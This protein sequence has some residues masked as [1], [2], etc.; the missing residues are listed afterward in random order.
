MGFMAHL[1]RFIFAAHRSPSCIKLREALAP[2]TH[3]PPPAASL[4]PSP[5]Q[6]RRLPPTCAPPS[7]WRGRPPT[8][9]VCPP[10][11]RHDGGPL[12]Q[13]YIRRAW[14]R[15]PPSGFP[16]AHGFGAPFRRAARVG[17]GLG[18]QR[19]SGAAVV[20]REWRGPISGT[21][22]VVDIERAHG[23]LFFCFSV[24]TVATVHVICVATVFCF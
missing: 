6:P 14:R 7:L 23:A 20:G 3:S 18:G 8:S 2:L 11:L 22:T 24:Q 17:D 5:P 19:V 9:G 21:V 10:Y 4:P 1:P 16:R 13:A 15:P 12:P